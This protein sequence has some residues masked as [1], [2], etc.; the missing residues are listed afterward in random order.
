MKQVA[1][2]SPRN[3]PLGAVRRIWRQEGWFGFAR[4]LRARLWWMGL[5]PWAPRLP[6]LRR[7]ELIEVAGRPL[8]SFA[9]GSATVIKPERG[10]MANAPFP[11]PEA[12]E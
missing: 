7:P 5:E 6:P 1:F 11:L 3:N 12:I 9:A 10:S 4:R 2:R 8:E